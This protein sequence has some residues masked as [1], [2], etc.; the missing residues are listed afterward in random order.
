MRAARMGGVAVVL[1]AAG[2]V[3]AD[4][5]YD[6]RGPA[7]VKGQTLASKS[8]LRM[9]D[10]SVEIALGGQK[11]KATQTMTIT[12]EEEEK[13][14]AVDGRQ[15]TRSQAKILKDHV[16]TVSEL[17]GE[18]TTEDQD[19]ELAGEVVV[20]ERTGEGKWRHSLVDSKPSDKQKKE[21]DKRLGPE[22]DDDLFPEGKV[23]VGHA[24]TVDAGRM[25]KFFGNSF[26]DVSGKVRQKFVRVET[27][28]G[29][30]CAVIEVAGP[31]KGKMK[32][33]DG[34]LAFELD[35]K[36]TTWR[37]LKTGVDVKDTIGG[38]MRLAGKQKVEDT[39]AD[40]VLEGTLKGEGTTTLK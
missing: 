28:S 15:V 21:L 24:W 18:D 39:P 27:V 22:C 40:I 34:D 10:A 36:G 5:T 3:R 6:L 38:R 12:S 4:E 8:V 30:R 31:I 16:K 7:P 19:G 11:L 17:M 20:S 37:S 26:T 2:A 25:K 32:D 33:E 14:L 1:L 29:E 23:K 9:K 13:F 35:L